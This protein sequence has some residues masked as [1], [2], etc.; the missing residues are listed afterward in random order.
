MTLR[1]CLDAPEIS[2]VYKILRHIEYL[3]TC[4]NPSLVLDN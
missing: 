2:K 1:P 3:D 4:E